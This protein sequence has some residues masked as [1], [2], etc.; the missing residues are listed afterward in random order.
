MPN[1][2]SFYILTDT[3]YVSKKNFTPESRSFASREKGDQIALRASAEILRSF[4]AK[5]NADPDTDA[6]LITGDLVNNGDRASHE[7]FINELKALTDAGKRVFVTTATHDYCGMGDDENFFSSCRYTDDG[8]EPIPHV[9]KCELADLYHDFGPAQSDSV[10]EESGSYSLRLFEGV[11]LIALNDNGNGRS[12]CGLFDA[13]FA[14]L[15]NEIGKANAAGERVLLA[16][17][18]PVIAPW[19]VYA[20]AVEFEVFGGYKRLWKLMCETGVRVVFTGHTHVQNIRR[21]EDEQGR[22][23]Y[24]VSTTAAVS[25]AGCMRKVTVSADRAE[26]KVETVRID[27]IDGF[28]TGGKSFHDYIYELNFIGAIEKALPLA[29]EDWDR[30]LQEA[31][32][33][34]P[35]DKLKEH[36]TLVKAGLRF[37]GKLKVKTVAKFGRK[38]GGITREEIKALGDEKAMPV[39]FEILKHI[40]SG[41]APYGPDT[42]EYK[43]MHG[44]VLR[45]EKLANRFKKDL[46]EKIVPPGQNLWDVAEPFVC[47]NR[48]GDD[49]NI[50]IAFDSNE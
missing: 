7:D 17:H 13:G 2:A 27:T 42:N 6:V 49:D 44:A 43:A 9:R 8:T 31:A 41:N 30:F 29:N 3:H 18:H 46:L 24:D 20:Q 26:C 14:W 16:V 39:L 36:K 12:H 5:I 47:N 10:D 48:T 1:A 15:E 45:A 38:Y 35:A 22:S 32:G 11:R 40:F 21:Y 50:T 25:S 19:D 28:D 34:L 23:F 4:I 33:P 37:A